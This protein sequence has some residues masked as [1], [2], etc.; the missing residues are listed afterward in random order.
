MSQENVELVRSFYATLNR[1]L[2]RHWEQPRSYAAGVASADPDPLVR[3]VLDKLDDDVRWIDIMGELRIGKV[4]WAEGGDALLQSV[5]A[6]RIAVAD[7]EELPSGRV[8]IEYRPELTGRASGIK[9]AE[10][11]FAVLAFRDGLISEL[12]EYS[13]RRAAREAEGLDD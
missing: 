2:E 7:I 5:Q 4:G 12:H 3:E 6:Y 1:N 10:S 9:G 13:S 11:L 8:L